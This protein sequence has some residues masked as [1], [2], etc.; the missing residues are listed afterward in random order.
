MAQT[1]VGS[2]AYLDDAANGVNHVRW[3]GPGSLGATWITP[4]LDLGNSPWHC[5]VSLH[6]SGTATNG[7]SPGTLDAWVHADDLADAV[8]ASTEDILPRLAVNFVGTGFQGSAH[9]APDTTLDASSAYTNGSFLSM[10][11][12]ASTGG[13]PVI[14]GPRLFFYYTANDTTGGALEHIDLFMWPAWR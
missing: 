1:V 11:S 8:A 6:G 14:F 2:W 12:T 13:L 3:T 10:Q 9:T 7:A 4:K 5:A